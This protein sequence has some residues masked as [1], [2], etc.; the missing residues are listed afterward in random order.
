MGAALR[1]SIHDP[2]T[3]SRGSGGNGFRGVNAGNRAR[4]R[5]QS[6]KVR[7]F[8]PKWGFYVQ[9]GAAD[10]PGTGFCMQKG[11]A[12]A[13]GTGFCMQKVAADTPGTGFCTLKVAADTPGTGFCRREMAAG[14]EIWGGWTRKTRPD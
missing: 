9:K 12:D 3:S 4:K 7:Q 2:R 14:E 6:V 8:V 1:I 11:A 5:I 10:A 13:S